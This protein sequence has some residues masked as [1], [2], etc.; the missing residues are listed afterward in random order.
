MST[1]SIDGLSTSQLCATMVNRSSC[2][3]RTRLYAFLEH[4]V[5]GC[6]RR[7]S[8]LPDQVDTCGAMR[9]YVPRASY[10][11]TCV[12]QILPKHIL[13]TLK[14]ETS[15]TA[16]MSRMAPNSTT[17]KAHWT[18]EISCHTLFAHTLALI[19]RPFLNPG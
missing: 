13:V 8:T 10:V 16:I 2:R 11:L 12:Q 14:S 1:S 7:V 3:A 15:I 4:H 19:R 18:F 6:P 17:N 5:G 9:G